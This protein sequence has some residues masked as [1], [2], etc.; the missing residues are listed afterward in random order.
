MV[1]GDVFRRIADEEAQ[2]TGDDQ[3]R[4]PEFG[5]LMM[6]YTTVL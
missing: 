1:Y 4:L 3:D 6:S 5:M 2:Y